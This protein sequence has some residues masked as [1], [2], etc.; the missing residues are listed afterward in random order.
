MKNHWFYNIFYNILRYEGCIRQACTLRPPCDLL[1][2]LLRLALSSRAQN[3]L[4]YNVFLGA[5]RGRPTA[6]QSTVMLQGGL[7]EVTGAPK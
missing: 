3:A 1:A 4:F 7:R 6:K 5:Q 2:T